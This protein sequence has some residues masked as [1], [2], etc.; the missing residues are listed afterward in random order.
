MVGFQKFRLVKDKSVEKD[1]KGHQRHGFG[2]FIAKHQPEVEG[3]QFAGEAPLLQPGIFGRLALPASSG[4]FF[5]V[6]IMSQE[7]AVVYK[8][9]DG[10]G[11]ETDGKQG[12]SDQ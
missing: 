7:P 3:Y 4:D 8:G 2:P 9:G 10:Q 5:E 12:R 11:N 6:E 1:D